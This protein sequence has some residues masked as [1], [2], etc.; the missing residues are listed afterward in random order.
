MTTLI[1][2]TTAGGKQRRCDARCYGARTPRCT[3]ICGGRNHG[4]GLERALQQTQALFLLPSVARQQRDEIKT[5][6][7]GA[8][9]GA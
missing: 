8:P 6:R 5:E 3:C 9:L 7:D 4:V 2:E 1:H